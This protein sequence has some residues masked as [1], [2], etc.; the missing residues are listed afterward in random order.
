ML[1]LLEQQNNYEKKSR[2]CNAKLKGLLEAPSFAN[3][4]AMRKMQANL[5][6]CT[7]LDFALKRLL[8]LILRS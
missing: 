5:T 8:E 3:A 2:I 4:A 7:N 1:E 6:E